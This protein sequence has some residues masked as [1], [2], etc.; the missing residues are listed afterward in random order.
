MNVGLLN[1]AIHDIITYK[2]D[3]DNNIVGNIAEV[4]VIGSKDL[5][6][7]NL[8]TKAISTCEIGKNTLSILKG[9]NDYLGRIR[10][11]TNGKTYLPK[12]NGQFYGNQYVRT[13][14]LKTIPNLG[15]FEKVY[16]LAENSSEL[17]VA[18][19]KDGGVWGNNCERCIAKIAGNYIGSFYGSR[20]GFSIGTGIGSGILSLPLGIG[21]S[22]VGDYLGGFFGGYIGEEL[23]NIY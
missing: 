2:Y 1:H 18:L 7:N 15:K 4:E 14:P 12:K 21:C 11:G 16:Q 13:T 8:Y 17:K 22:L 20:I 10:V 23:Y 5:Y 3:K 6:E 19:V 9:I